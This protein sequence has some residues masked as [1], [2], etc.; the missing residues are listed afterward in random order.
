MCN[1]LPTEH[2]PSAMQKQSMD[3]FSGGNKNKE[4]NRK[5]AQ[6]NIYQSD[7]HIFAVIFFIFS[8]NVS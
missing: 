5:T 8:N 2:R 6:H 7:Y 4:L 1:E 3:T